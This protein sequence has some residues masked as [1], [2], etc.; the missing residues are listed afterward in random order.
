MMSADESVS[1]PRRPGLPGGGHASV[2]SGHG[3]ID[4]GKASPL[5]N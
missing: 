4:E 3:Y 2:R 5:Y 1:N